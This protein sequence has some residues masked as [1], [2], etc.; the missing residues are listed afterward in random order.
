M[1]EPAAERA[2]LTALFR[3]HNIEPRRALGQNFIIDDTVCPRIADAVGGDFSVLEIG[4]GAGALTAR[5][6]ER[7]KKVVAVEIDPRMSALLA[8]RFGSHSNIEV[9]TGDAMKLDLNALIAERFSSNERVAVAGN[10]PY[11]ITTP[12]IMRFLE[13]HLRVE[14]VVAMVQKEAAERLCA[15]E[16]SRDCGAVTLAVRYYS[17][18]EILFDVSRGSFYPQPDVT[19]SVMRMNIREA[20]LVT[21]VDEAFMFKLIKAAF[22]QRRK[23]ACN[24]ISNV[25]GLDKAA[26]AKAI[27]AVGIPD[28]E[29]AERIS[30]EQFARLSDLLCSG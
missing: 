20:P 30:L 4:P 9:V 8:E 7:A 19:S 12:L 28:S 13:E 6:A 23:T 3:K 27:S 2:V 11:Y 16:Q 21:P 29:R 15:A 5:L 25:A 22:A 26:V 14:R 18:P 24:S 1:G 17:E 10:L